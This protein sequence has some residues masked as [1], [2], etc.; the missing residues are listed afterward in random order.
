MP[1]P[2][3]K[4]GYHTSIKSSNG[5]YHVGMTKAQAQKAQSY[6][7]KM[8]IDFKDLDKDGDGVLSQKEILKGRVKAAERDIICSAGF[9]AIAIGGTVTVGMVG[10]P[11]T[12]GA[13]AVAAG[14]LIAN[15]LCS[16]VCRRCSE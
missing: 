13:S 4:N 10:V 14:S 15:S 8:G 16:G 1:D 2:I 7:A 11:L 12:G 3:S 9:G 5:S 6:Q